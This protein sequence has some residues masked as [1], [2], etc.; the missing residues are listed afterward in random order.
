MDQYIYPAVFESAEE[1]GYTVTFPD[2]PGCITEGNT[3][4]EALD[5]A[6]ESLELY[7]YNLEDDKEELPNS[8]A[9]ESIHVSEGSFVV[10]IIAWMPMIRDEMENKA[11]KKTL[12]IPKWLN[13]I[14]EENKIN[15]SQVLQVALKEK[16]NIR[17]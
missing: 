17:K 13:D 10:P 11:V 1:G 12:T 15:F 6:T 4:K 14:A 2:L 9:P 3:V 8:S 5:M 7:M 16:L